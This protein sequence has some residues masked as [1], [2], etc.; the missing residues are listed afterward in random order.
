MFQTKMLVCC[1]SALTFV[2]SICCSSHQV[3]D[4]RNES[5]CLTAQ[6]SNYVI[7]LQKDESDCGAAAIAT[8]A[9]HYKIPVSYQQLC[10]LLG[11]T[12]NG[13][14]LF[15]TVYHTIHLRGKVSQNRYLTQNSW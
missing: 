9:L 7:V 11:I 12:K 8:L 2:I 6:E 13:A 1:I 10:S 5:S 4:L 3:A 15:R 14:S